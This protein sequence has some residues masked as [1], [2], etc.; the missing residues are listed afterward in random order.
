MSEEND[1]IDKHIQELLSKML[2][3][4]YV[5]NN[6]KANSSLHVKSLVTSTQEYLTP[7]I[8]FGYD[9]KGDAIVVTDAKTR[10]DFDCLMAS[11]SRY[12]T[13]QRLGDID[14]EIGDMMD[15]LDDG[16]EEEE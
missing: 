4:D 6:K 5:D 1:N 2:N 12:L 14:S 11:I 13:Q 10:K 8:T 9:I 16:L 3:V 15:D 7:F